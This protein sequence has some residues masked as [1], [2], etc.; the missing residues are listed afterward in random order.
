MKVGDKAWV[1]VQDSQMPVGVKEI[2]LEETDL[3]DGRR[4]GY[5]LCSRE[6]AESL[7]AVIL[8]AEIARLEKIAVKMRA[9]AARH[10]IEVALPDCAARP[11][12]LPPSPIGAIISE[13][14][15]LT[16]GQLNE[17]RQKL[18][19]YRGEIIVGDFS[20]PTVERVQRFCLISDDDGHWYVIPADKLA[21]A[22]AHFEAVYTFWRNPPDDEDARPADD[23]E[24]MERVNGGA[25][26]VTFAF[27]EIT[28]GPDA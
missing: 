17:L 12:A 16:P 15:P 3:E 18:A 10:G 23:P 2:T 13:G 21:E 19:D 11:F 20:L 7:M 22:E 1:I 4:R 6:D 27:P 14:P 25:S 24:W 8:K 26:L 5:I 9:V 28:E